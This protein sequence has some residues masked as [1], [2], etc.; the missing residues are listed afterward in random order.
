MILVVAVILTVVLVVSAG[1]IDLTTL[2]QLEYFVKPQ[3]TLWGIATM[4]KPDSVNIQ[5][6][7]YRLR[8]LNKITPE[9]YPGQKIIIFDGR[10]YQ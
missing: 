3:D 8:E 1:K 5:Y 2:P 4:Y 7:V 6:Y 10:N 9:L